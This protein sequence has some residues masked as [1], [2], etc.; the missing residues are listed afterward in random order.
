MLPRSAALSVLSVL[1][2]LGLLL[3]GAAAAIAATPEEMAP[4]GRKIMFSR[5]IGFT[6]RFP[7]AWFPEKQYEMIVGDDTQGML[8]PGPPRMKTIM[9]RGRPVQVPDLD[10]PAAPAYK[11]RA[12][13]AT[14]GIP[15]S[16]AAISR[17]WAERQMGVAMQWNS[18]DYYQD[19][20]N[21][22]FADPKWAL[23]DITCW[24]GTASESC[25]L[26]AQWADRT[27]VVQ[28]MGKPT[29]EANKGIIDS[30]EVMSLASKPKS[31]NELATNPKL[32]PMSWREDQL[33]RGNVITS[34]GKVVRGSTAMPP[35]VWADFCEAETEH[36]RITCN[37]GPARLMQHAAY[38]EG[39][40]RAYNKI[41]MP[42]RMPP[43]KLEIHIFDKITQFENGARAWIDPTFQAR[44]MGGII[45]GF[46]VP[47]LVS[48]WVYEESYAITKDPEFAVEFVSAHECT[49]Q[50]MHLALNGNPEIP[51]WVKEG[52]AVLF[53]NG[54]FANGEFGLRPPNG[55]IRDL[56]SMYQ[57]NASAAGG[58][59]LQPLDQY[60]EH[61]GHIS[62][63][64]YA[65]V[66]AI[67]HFWIYGTGKEGLTRMQKFMRA[68]KAGENGSKAFEEI[69][70]ADIIKTKGSR[71]A[72]IETWTKM[73]I[74]YV[75]SP[76]IFNLVPPTK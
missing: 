57:Y 5:D 2:V 20:V 50:F 73:L 34:K 55:R 65:E 63:A 68:L 21:R 70:L 47:K 24:L 52:L 6:V 43:Y 11:M 60:L 66:F 35:S 36:Y 4:M 67:V 33:K 40:Y 62:A 28:M 56:R 17:S 53:E 37:S 54:I 61:H 59:T 44:G 64:Q 72:A 51:T 23:S 38:Y 69:F 18:Y 16:A 3:A 1:S 32:K 75:N 10:T 14:H 8:I 31:T 30:F 71:E 41:F 7:Y 25:A 39:L 58:G 27:V 13:S 74:A 49:H 9:V 15:A 48:V 22:P 45:G 29:D 26:L 46:F 42:D 76:A 19:P 12:F